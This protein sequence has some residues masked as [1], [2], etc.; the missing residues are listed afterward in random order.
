MV[1]EQLRGFAGTVVQLGRMVACHG[2]ADRH[3]GMLAA[4]MHDWERAELHFEAALRLNGR[5]QVVTWLAHTRYEHAR[6]LLARRQPG[7][8]ERA[9]DLLE[10]VHRTAARAGLAALL[11]RSERLLTHS[12]ALPDGL[13]ERELEVLRLVARGHSNREIG[14]EL[15]ISQNTAA[16]HVRSILMKTQCGNRTEAAFYAHR[17]ALL[18]MPG[19]P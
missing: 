7:D 12:S 10:H 11:A 1:Y 2:V 15:F 14:R 17:N 4:T 8:A 3:L 6:M 18:D 9:S 5:M 13:T 16:N 19:L